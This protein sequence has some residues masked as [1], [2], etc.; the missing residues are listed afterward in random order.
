RLVEENPFIQFVY[1]TDMEGKKTTRNITQVVDKAKYE[2]FG[3]GEDFSNRDWFIG[4]LK[5][6]KI[7]ITDLYKSAIT[8]ALCLTVS[9][10]IRDEEETIVG[11]FGVDIRFEDLTKVEQEDQF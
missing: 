10:P 11:V 5:D 1:V 2:C 3:L 9:A 4:P 8:G 6:G 7:H